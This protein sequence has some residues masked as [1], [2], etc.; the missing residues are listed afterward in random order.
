MKKT[1]TILVTALAI[2]AFAQIPTSGLVGYYPFTGNANDLSGN[3][4]NGTVT[5]ATLTIDRF[6]NPNSAYSF[7]GTSDKIQIANSSSLQ[8]ASNLQSISFWIKIPSIPSPQY[9]EP[10]IEKY[11]QHLTIDANGNAGQG[12][13]VQFDGSGN[14]HYSFKNG[15]GH[16]WADCIIPSSNLSANQNYHITYTNDNDSLRGFVNCVKVSSTKIPVGTVIGTNTVSLLIGNSIQTSAGNNVSPFSGIADDIRLYDRALNPSEVCT[17]SNEG[18][19]YQYITV[20]DT[21]LINTSITG[22]NPVTYQNTIKIFPNPTHDQITINYGNYSAM[23]GYTL[24]ITNSL[25]QVMFTTLIN[26]AQSTVNLSTWTGNGLY[27]VNIIDATGNI[28]DIKKIVL[29]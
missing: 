16:N 20:T 21:L 25:G 17:L 13:V 8:F 11:D 27:F 15:I 29:Q 24:K 26:Q 6:G 5:G 10:I 12:Y 23:S 14:L 1:I 3:N 28:I 7:N 22:F 19:C 9:I 2:N 4:N 18:L